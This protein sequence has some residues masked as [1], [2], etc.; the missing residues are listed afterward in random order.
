MKISD[1][2]EAKFSKPEIMYHGTTSKNLKSVLSNGLNDYKVGGGWGSEY[3]ANEKMRDLGAIGGVYLSRSVD[4][5]WDVAID[6]AT[7]EY[8]AMIV[9]V[10]YQSRSGVMDEDSLDD[11]INV[12]MLNIGQSY[13]NTIEAYIDQQLTDSATKIFMKNFTRSIKHPIPRKNKDNVIK[14]SR[15]TINA[16]LIRKISYSDID[17]VEIDK[18][19][20][21]TALDA[22]EIVNTLTVSSKDAEEG[23]KHALRRLTVVLKKEV[24]I[25]DYQD[26]LRSRESI[27]YRGNNKII[28]IYV[29]EDDVVKVKYGTL[30]D[31][32]K[33][34]FQKGHRFTIE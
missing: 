5:A 1:L 3:G 6:I 23:L 29:V 10:Q 18:L 32:A 2:Y 11:V 19:V 22:N 27:N 21:G 17:K 16:E 7:K 26:T 20:G 33:H 25:P 15:D 31:E 28:G 13:G 30:T 14:A 9:A 24:V 34:Y 12:S 8:N 4:L